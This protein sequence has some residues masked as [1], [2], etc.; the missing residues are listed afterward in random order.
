MTQ[1]TVTNGQLIGFPTQGAGVYNAG[2]LNISESNF[3]HN[4]CVGDGTRGGAIYNSSGSVS[5]KNTTFYSNSATSFAP[6]GG[7][8]YSA[9]G[10]LDILNSSFVDNLAGDYY[11]LGGAIYSSSVAT[12]TNSTFSGNRANDI[13]GT[14]FVSSGSSLLLRNSIVVNGSGAL[15]CNGD[16][17]DGGGNISWPDSSCPGL[18]QDPKL[19][20]A[21]E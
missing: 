9:G 19:Q 14:I 15:G 7:A 13:G 10:L 18:N 2:R 16:I 11:D 5:I 20:S 1:L 17:V 12:I 4:H 3:A 6:I 21:G 8:I